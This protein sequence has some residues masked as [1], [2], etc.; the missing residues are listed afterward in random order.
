MFS[1][2]FMY[3]KIIVFRW[4]FKNIQFNVSELHRN[5]YLPILLVLNLSPYALKQIFLKTYVAVLPVL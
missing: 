3:E 1:N 5:I 2:N 4:F